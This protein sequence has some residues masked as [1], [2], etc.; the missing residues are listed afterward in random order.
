MKSV[1]NPICS[2]FNIQ[3]EINK[4]ANHHKTPYIEPNTHEN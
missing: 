1:L 2:A 4:C 3:Q